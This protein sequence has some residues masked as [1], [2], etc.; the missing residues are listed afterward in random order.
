MDIFDPFGRKKAAR[1]KAAREAAERAAA[2]ASRV[3]QEKE[4]AA[5]NAEQKRQADWKKLPELRL[6]E[7]GPAQ[8]LFPKDEAYKKK[9]LIR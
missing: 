2:D 9:S 4:A 3:Q 8:R 6:K 1:E 5:L 7:A